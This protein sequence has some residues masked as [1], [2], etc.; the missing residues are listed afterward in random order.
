MWA[1]WGRRRVMNRHSQRR[2]EVCRP[3][4]GSLS[5]SVSDRAGY[6]ADLVNRRLMRIKLKHR[7]SAS[8]EMRV[9]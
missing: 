4:V 9:P 5:A 1:D 6:A 8:R 7:I 3:S 2:I